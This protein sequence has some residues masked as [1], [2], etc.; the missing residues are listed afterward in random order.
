VQPAKGCAEPNRSEFADTKSSNSTRSAHARR[1]RNVTDEV[2]HMIN[3]AV[4]AYIVLGGLL[5]LYL[6]RVVHIWVALRDILELP[7]VIQI[8]RVKRSAFRYSSR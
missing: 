8:H 3:F 5:A 7:N 1:E 2:R 4:I 6:A